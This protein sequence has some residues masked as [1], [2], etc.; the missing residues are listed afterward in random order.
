MKFDKYEFCLAT[1]VVSTLQCIQMYNAVLL[2]SRISIDDK[3]SITHEIPSDESQ[4]MYEATTSKKSNDDLFF[5]DKIGSK[6][7]SKLASSENTVQPVAQQ[8]SEPSTD[9]A[10][11]IKSSTGQPLS[12]GSIQKRHVIH[13]EKDTSQQTSQDVII[14]HIDTSKFKVKYYLTMK[15]YIFINVILV[16]MIVG[17]I[18]G[19]D[20]MGW[21]EF[22]F[23]MSTVFF[24]NLVEL[25]SI[26]K[27]LSEDIDP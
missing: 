13:K 21:P 16:A 11:S 10:V 2:A 6:I 20:E 3:S 17:F 9:Y 12:V 1:A 14:T 23:A 4:E 5:T 7:S 19:S 15:I 26:P 22:A 8:H 27:I 18:P 24:I 25:Y